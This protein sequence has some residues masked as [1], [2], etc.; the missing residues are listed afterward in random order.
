M[1]RAIRPIPGSTAIITTEAQ[2]RWPVVATGQLRGSP[3]RESAMCAH[4]TGG[5]MEARGAER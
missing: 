3:F 1:N 2:G 4:G 5:A